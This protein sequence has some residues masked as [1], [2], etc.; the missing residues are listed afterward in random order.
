ML[1]CA[2][3]HSQYRPI[4]LSKEDKPIFRKTKGTNYIISGLFVDDVM[5][6]SFSDELKKE[7]MEK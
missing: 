6:I 4:F 3:F 5:H 2:I 7:F 1:V